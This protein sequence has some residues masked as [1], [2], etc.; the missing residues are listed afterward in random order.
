MSKLRF[1][2]ERAMPGQP[3]RTV[4]QQPHGSVTNTPAPRPSGRYMNSIRQAPSSLSNRWPAT[5]ASPARGS[6]PKPTS[7]TRS[8]DSA[9]SIGPGRAHRYL[10][11]NAP[12]T[13][14]YG[15]ASKSPSSATA[16][17]P[18]RT[19]GYAASSPAPSARTAT[20]AEP[21]QSS[22]QRIAVRSQSGRADRQP[23]STA[24]RS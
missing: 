17:S 7:K 8:A 1:E 15:S 24:P 16:N 5:L 22:S 4:L 11:G 23:A 13:T 9:P 19:S 10:P 12:V 20:T 21:H 6:T 18:M 14:P 2:V 3:R